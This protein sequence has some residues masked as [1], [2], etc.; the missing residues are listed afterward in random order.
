MALEVDSL[1]R[2]GHDIRGF[3]WY[4]SI[5]ST[6]WCHACTKSTNTVDPQ[7][8]WLLDASRWNRA[9]SE[10][11]ATYSRLAR[12]LTSPHDVPAYRVTAPLD[13]D[14]RGYLKLMCGWDHW[15]EP[16]PAVR[17]A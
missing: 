13:R 6:D 3:C 15:Q 7:G 10:L 5:D 14:L 16:T 4:P 9:G 8:I 17:V 1:I 2:D 12:S 11:S